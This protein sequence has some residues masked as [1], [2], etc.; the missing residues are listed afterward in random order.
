M[1]RSWIGSVQKEGILNL[2]RKLSRRMEET[3]WMKMKGRDECGVSAEPQRDHP[4]RGGWLVWGRWRALLKILYQIPLISQVSCAPSFSCE[5]IVLKEAKYSDSGASHIT[6][7]WGGSPIAPVVEGNLQSFHKWFPSL[8]YFLKEPAG[9]LLARRRS[10]RSLKEDNSANCWRLAGGGRMAT[11]PQLRECVEDYQRL[12]FP[13]KRLPLS[14]LAPP[15]AVT[16][17]AA[18]CHS[19]GGSE[20]LGRSEEL[21]QDSPEKS[22]SMH[23]LWCTLQTQLPRD[24]EKDFNVGLHLRTARCLCV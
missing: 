8:Y 13:K 1:R 20:P 6:P 16:R 2:C 5:L 21:D 17:M 19:F 10:Y 4:S 23:W 22:T 7:Q 3:A 15:G 12:L 18:K 11:W 14:S 9:L 24:E